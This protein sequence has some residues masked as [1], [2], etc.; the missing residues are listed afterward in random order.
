MMQR[1]P[2]PSTTSCLLDG[3]LADCLPVDDRGLAYG[4][5]LFETLAFNG[6]QPRFWQM[7]M[8]RLA[9]GCERL[10][11]EAPAQALLLR[12]VRTVA[13]GQGRCVVKLIITRG[14]GGRGYRPGPPGAARRVVSV[15][16]WPDDIDI[17][18][19]EGVVARTCE[20]RLAV[21][22]ALGGF[23]HLNRL[24][25]VLAARELADVP[26]LEGIL[27]DTDGH[28]ICGLSANLFLVS[29]QRLLTPRVDRCGVR[30]VTRALILRDFQSRCEL[31]RITPD[32]LGEADEV[33][34]CNSLRGILPV[35][36]IDQREWPIGPVAR[37][38]QA[39]FEQRAA[40]S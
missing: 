5:G 36:R 28:L 25:Q 31:R 11:I 24:E 1:A 18:Q 30:G 40:E 15:H 27:L 38:L 29:D 37:D 2:E 34:L 14:S 22:P 35:T 8:D 9:R 4:D 6:G 3:E 20:I 19:R 12:E 16:R 21:Q 7:H 17:Q 33:F 39:W 23:K 13:A 10:G 32:M 26:G